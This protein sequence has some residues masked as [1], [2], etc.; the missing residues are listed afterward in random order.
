MHW[1]LSSRGF[2]S[3]PRITVVCLFLGLLRSYG[4]G[5][6]LFTGAQPIGAIVLTRQASKSEKEAA[7]A[8]GEYVEKMAGVK[9]KLL[10]DGKS[11]RGAIFLAR[12]AVRAGGLTT[13]EMAEAGHEGY[14][15]RVRDGNV[16]L[17][18][19]KY[20]GTLYG[21]Y[22]FLQQLGARFYSHD[23]E[24][25]PPVRRITVPALDILR[26]PVFELRTIK[27]M[28]MRLGQHR[29]DRHMMRPN[30]IDPDLTTR[31][32]WVHSSQYLAPF[33]K[34][35]KS[36]P[37][38]Y[39]QREDGSFDAVR[40][41]NSIGK[42]HICMSNPKV[43]EIAEQRLIEAIQ[44][45]PDRRLFSVSQS[46][47]YGWCECE[48][49]RAIDTRPGVRTDRLLD[50][51]NELARAVCAKYPDK[52]IMTLAYCRDT[53]PVPERTMPEPNVR[54]VLCPYTPEVQDK[55]HWFDHKLNQ[56]FLPWYAAWVKLLP[57]GR[58]F[59][60]DYPYADFRSLTFF[61]EHHFD[62]IKRYARDGV[63][64]IN[65]DGRDRFMFSLFEYVTSRLVWNPS[66]ETRPLIE[67]F[68][69][70]YYG[71]A[72]PIVL[73]I[74]DF[75]AKIAALDDRN[76]GPVLDMRKFVTS[77]ECDTLFGLFAEAEEAAKESA[78]H[79]ARVK[80][81]KVYLLHTYLSKHNPVL[82][83][84]SDM[85]L[86][87]RRL[88]EYVTLLL[89]TRTRSL[90]RHDIRRNSNG[91]RSWF[92]RVARLR[93]T[94]D[95]IKDDPILQKLVANPQ[96]VH[97]P[98]AGLKP[99]IELLSGTKGWRIPLELSE[100]ARRRDSYGYECP[101]REN[102][103][104]LR[105]R[106]TEYSLMRLKFGLHETPGAAT[107]AIDGQDDEKPGATRI[108]I[109]LNDRELFRGPNR[110]KEKGWSTCR[111]RVPAGLLVKGK[112]E[113]VIEDLEEGDD[114]FAQWV[115]VVDVRIETQRVVSP[116]P[117][118][119]LLLAHFDTSPNA[120]FSANPEAKING[121]IRL[122]HEGKWG[123]ALDMGYREPAKG[124][125]YFEGTDNISPHAG[126]AEMWVKL[127]WDPNK[128]TLYRTFLFTYHVHHMHKDGFL[129]H[130]YSGHPLRLKYLA[131]YG[132]GPTLTGNISAWQPH[133]WHHVAL[134]WD[135]KN[136]TRQLFLDG[137]LVGLDRKAKVGAEQPDI[138]YVGT[139]HR[140]PEK[141]RFA[142]ALIDELRITDGV[143]WQGAKVGEKMF[144][145][146]T[147]PYPITK[148][149]PQ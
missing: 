116:P 106:R 31:V 147:Q 59:I 53:A 87:K 41:K 110:F 24:V 80:E 21:A 122:S 49:C 34:Y 88:G 2:A 4:A 15:I 105:T 85:P 96:S 52:I 134:T 57:P 10:A 126:T 145:P 75:M 50:F 45:Q 47:G 104:V 99:R 102:V 98:K 30:D 7:D 33:Y 37:E 92:W 39:A 23:H 1:R 93:I 112:N 68:V 70:S 28:I 26:R 72:G 84:A 36:N 118:R 9:L 120:D 77:E 140:R 51:V 144:D 90:F 32:G 132:R 8:L 130:R 67:D 119:T 12:A 113:L 137:V 58:M 64:G 142:G 107:L 138:I 22:H 131:Y 11:Q 89:T 111:H 42:L 139:I 20:Y 29:G 74:Y 61:H 136:H 100:G 86:F 82:G 135:A 108:R 128:D 13:K 14:R 129:L 35:G 109:A 18:G 73:R 143:L 55:A 133:T 148:D 46:D 69:G 91:A 16:Y 103:Y 48:K 97:I 25:I 63:R 125:L 141:A 114:V 27:Y 124:T 43:R 146:A 101:R 17:A 54:I 71:A 123:G 79:L 66:L 60:F 78:L 127:G 115:I 149:I 65:Y 38:Y 6:G 40:M 121:K 117:A 62:R 95:S 76:Q 81:D 83:T 19:G 94:A 56:K 44:K 5:K 3:R